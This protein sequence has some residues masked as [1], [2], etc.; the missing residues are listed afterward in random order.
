MPLHVFETGL[1]VDPGAI[2]QNQRLLTAVKI[3]R[4][5]A[6]EDI[7]AGLFKDLTIADRGLF[8]LPS[9]IQDSVLGPEPVSAG[10]LDIIDMNE[11]AFTAHWS[12]VSAQEQAVFNRL[13]CNSPGWQP[14]YEYP[15]E[16]YPVVLAEPTDP[17]HYKLTTLMYCYNP[18][19][20]FEAVPDGFIATQQALFPYVAQNAMSVHSVMD[21][22]AL[23]NGQRG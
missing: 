22:I 7:A 2:S 13:V 9:V 14:S 5:E 4:D 23:V 12:P 18:E 20:E 6:G 1:L 16:L 17:Q 21:Q 19:G 11:E 15:I 3:V 8:V 10:D